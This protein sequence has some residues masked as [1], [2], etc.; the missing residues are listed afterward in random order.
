[1]PWSGPIPAELVQM[2]DRLLPGWEGLD[3]GDPAPPPAT[4]P[5]TLSEAQPPANALAGLVEAAHFA[6]FTIWRLEDEARRRDVDDARIAAT[7]RAIDAWNQRRNDLMEAVDAAVL[8]L[9]G[10]SMPDDAELH[11]ETP[12]MILDRLGV[13][14]LK[15]RNAA[16]VAGEA[17]AAGDA[18]LVA[19]SGAREAVLRGQRDDLALCL[20]RLLDDCADGR[21]RFKRYLQLKS[22]NDEKTNLALRAASSRANGKNP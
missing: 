16:R 11:S 13:L 9:V 15:I 3:L 18:A 4:G 19:E 7:K 6:N 5:R 21:R 8:A 1:M 22:Y 12:G 14:A 10:A 17:A 20:A 2:Q